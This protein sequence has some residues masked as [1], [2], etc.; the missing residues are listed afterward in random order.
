MALTESEEV[1]TKGVVI[2]AVAEQLSQL[3]LRLHWNVAR[4]RHKFP[5][6][7]AAAHLC[8]KDRNVLQAFSILMR[9]FQKSTLNRMWWHD[10]KLL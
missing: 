6:R 8:I 9:A 3:D 7:F 1:Q 10:G 2:V 5:V 4:M